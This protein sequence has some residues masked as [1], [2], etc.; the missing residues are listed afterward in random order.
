MAPRHCSG[1]M[2]R[3]TFV[4]L[5]FFFFQAEDGIRDRTVTGV[6]TCALPIYQRGSQ[7][8]AGNLHDWFRGHRAA[9]QA[10]LAIA[11]LQKVNLGSAAAQA[12]ANAFARFVQGVALGNLSLAY[13]SASILTEFDNPEADASVIVAL[14]SERAV[15]VAA[16]AYLDSAIAIAQASPTGTF[17]LPVQPNFWFNGL[18]TTKAEF[19][20]LARS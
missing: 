6:Q 17:P 20:Q 12:R 19:I 3:S 2:R 14:S 13:D 10:A 15:N 1:K 5:L 18:A 16:L 11:A 9:R 4:R 8:S 7:G